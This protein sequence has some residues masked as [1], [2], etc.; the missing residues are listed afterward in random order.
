MTQFTCL[1]GQEWA[2]QKKVL[3]TYHICILCSKSVWRFFP[4]LCWTGFSILGIT[5][6]TNVEMS[7]FLKLQTAKRQ[8]YNFSVENFHQIS[9]YHRVKSVEK[10][11]TGKANFAHLHQDLPIKTWMTSQFHQL[12]TPN[13]W[14][15]SSIT[16]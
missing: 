14:I 13:G 7:W 16:T 3:S 12:S 9:R 4:V 11:T 8:G 2:A 1:L 15:K 10:L 5:L 6:A